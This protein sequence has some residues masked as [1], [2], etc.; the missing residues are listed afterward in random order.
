MQFDI[1]THAD[2]VLSE[3]LVNQKTEK[4]LSSQTNS[5]YPIIHAQNPWRQW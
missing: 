3:T 1:E 5:I 4:W 2:E